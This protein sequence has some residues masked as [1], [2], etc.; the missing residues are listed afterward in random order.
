MRYHIDTIPV[1]DAYKAD[2]ECPLCDLWQ[3]CEE[4]YLA[5]FVGGSV[6]EPD[7]RVR[8][9]ETGF[10]A[11]HLAG[12]FALQ[13]RLP[14]ALMAHT[15]MMAVIDRMAPPTAPKNTWFPF[16]KRRHEAEA[17]RCILCSR[18]DETME[19]YLYTVL[20]LWKT[21]TEFRGTFERSK[22][23]C[24]PHYARL[25]RMAEQALGAGRRAEF[26]G[27][28]FELQRENMRRVEKELHWFTQKFD[29]RNHEAPW[30][31]SK[32][33]VERTVWKLRGKMGGR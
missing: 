7:E 33:A 29:Y 3:H 30:G 26:G 4:K 14:L 24:M 17:E 23:L 15:H 16:V 12:L 2:S 10:C 5:Y 11:E 21:D 19:R 20:H 18:L 31:N 13:Q 28:L 22:G 6:M 9:N 8:V 25:S 1:W 32:D 27:V